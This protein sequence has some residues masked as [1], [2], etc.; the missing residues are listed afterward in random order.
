MNILLKQ[1]VEQVTETMKQDYINWCTSNGKKDLSGYHKEVI[2]NWKIEI[3]EGQKYIR[4]HL[5][6]VV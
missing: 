5:V 1:A 4:V 6:A 2:D 3:K